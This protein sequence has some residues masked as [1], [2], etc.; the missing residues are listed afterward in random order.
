VFLKAIQKA[1]SKK[2]ITYYEYVIEQRGKTE[3]ELGKA[4][5]H[6]LFLIMVLNFVKRSQN[7]KTLLKRN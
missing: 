5:I 4:F 7:F 1:M 6:I 2:G 3:E